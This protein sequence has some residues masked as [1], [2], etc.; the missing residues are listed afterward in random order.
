V[1]PAILSQ[2][3]GKDELETKNDERNPDTNTTEFEEG[4]NMSD[5]N[6]FQ[7]LIRRVRA[8]D[9][10]AAGELV[11]TYEPAIRR[12]ARVRLV[13]KRLGRVLDSMDICQSVLASF[14]VRAALGQYELDKPEQLLKLLATMARNKLADHARQEQAGRRDNRRTEAGSAEDRQLAASGPTPSQQ[15]AAKEIFHEVHRRLTPD[16]RI[17]ADHR[18]QGR[19]WIEIAAEVGGTPEALR[20]RLSRAIDR[21]AGELGLDE[22]KL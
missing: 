8:G 1:S 21:V 4:G 14:F 2:G 12:A 22:L 3:R 16:E 9:A 7:D 19:E 6:A 15:V 5:E 20:K 10:A 18:A 17:L 13:D 11:R